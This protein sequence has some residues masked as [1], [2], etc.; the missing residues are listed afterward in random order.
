MIICNRMQIN[1]IWKIS[2]KFTSSWPA[3]VCIKC[4]TLVWDLTTPPPGQWPCRTDSRQDKVSVLLICTNGE[5]YQRE[6]QMLMW[7]ATGDQSIN[8][9]LF[10]AMSEYNT[11]VVNRQLWTRQWG[12]STNHCPLKKLKN[13]IKMMSRIV[14]SRPVTKLVDDS[15][16]QLHSD[17]CSCRRWCWWCCHLAK[18]LAV[19]TLVK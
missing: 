14:E 16:L 10:A 1:C 7:S 19:K 8:Q 12:Q 3:V 9:S 15:L 6:K 18:R 13:K 2:V 4:W 17:E 5:L 11:T